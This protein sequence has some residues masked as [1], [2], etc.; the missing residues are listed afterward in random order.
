MIG[1]RVGNWYVETE[2]THGATGTVYRARGFD[3]P[4]RRA[5][6]RVRRR[7]APAGDRPV[8]AGALGEEAR[9]VSGREEGVGRGD[10]ERWLGCGSEHGVG[11]AGDSELDRIV[12]AIESHYGTKRTHIPLMGVANLFVKVAHPVGAS[13]FKLAVFE[14]LESSPSYGRHAEL[15]EFIRGISGSS[16]HPLVRLHSRANNESTYIFAGEA[17]RSTRMLIATFQR[18]E[19]TVIE[20]KVSMETLLKMVESPERA[21]KFSGSVTDH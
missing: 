9:E 14:N 21:R 17:G 8:R 2:L 15:D 13:G 1:A 11:G 7:F 18:N 16:L 20:V 5:V 4:E 10:D 19:A 6:R 3:D 12:Q